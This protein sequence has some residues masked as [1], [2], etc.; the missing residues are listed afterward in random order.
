MR[1]LT[2]GNRRE[3]LGMSQEDLTIKS[4]VH[5][6]YAGSVERGERNVSLK[7]LVRFANA[8]NV[9]LSKLISETESLAKK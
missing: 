3:K 6:T 4:G 1:A 9:P 5:R 2:T 8:L 7:N